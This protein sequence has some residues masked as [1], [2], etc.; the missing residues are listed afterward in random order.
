MNAQILLEENLSAE[1][2][3]DPIVAMLRNKYGFLDEPSAPK[4]R[5]FNNHKQVPMTQQMSDS[6]TGTGNNGRTHKLVCICDRPNK[7]YQCVAC[8]LYMWGRAAKICEKHPS[9][10]FLMD[11]REC[12]YC[13][14][15]YTIN[16]TDFLEED[17]EKFNARLPDDDD[18][19]L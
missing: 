3:P 7:V 11:F 2:G 4:N 17:I 12:P 15:D 5:V 14:A 16:E 9:V 13:A 1:N 18:E 6:T 19:D 10:T 8:Y